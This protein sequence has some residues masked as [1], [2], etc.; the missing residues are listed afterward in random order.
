MMAHLVA[1]PPALNITMNTLSTF[2]KVISALS[3]AASSL[4]RNTEILPGFSC[5]Q[6]L[7]FCFKDFLKIHFVYKMC[8]PLCRIIIPCLKWPDQH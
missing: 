6:G 1:G 5:D 3:Q 7:T 8:L 4:S 2:L